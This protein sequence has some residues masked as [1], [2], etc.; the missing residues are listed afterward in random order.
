[1]GF[2]TGTTNQTEVTKLEC[3]TLLGRGME[4]ISLTGLLV[5]Y[6]LFQMYTTPTLIQSTCSSG[7]A[8][9]WHPTKYICLS[10]TLYIS[11]LV[12]GGKRYHVI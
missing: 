7:D 9:T 1:M 5:T 4:L 6:V 8:T 12:L 2:Q 11:L 3:N 10:S